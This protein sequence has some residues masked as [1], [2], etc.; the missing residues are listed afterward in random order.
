MLTISVKCIPS[1]KLS[2]FLRSVSVRPGQYSRLRKFK[3][4][5]PAIKESLLNCEPSR[6][7][8]PLSYFGRKSSSRFTSPTI[9]EMDRCQNNEPYSFVIKIPTKPKL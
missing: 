7:K 2:Q 8:I 5:D 3:R 1:G 6:T 9:S 4:R